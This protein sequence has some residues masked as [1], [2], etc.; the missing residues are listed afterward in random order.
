MLGIFLFHL[1]RRLHLRAGLGREKG[2]IAFLSAY[3]Y[4]LAFAQI[5]ARDVDPRRGLK[6]SKLMPSRD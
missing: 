1:R 5:S 4:D 2:E 3:R 6:N